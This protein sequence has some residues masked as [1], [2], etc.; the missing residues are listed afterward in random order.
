MEGKL[1]ALNNLLSRRE[2]TKAQTEADAKAK[3]LAD[4]IQLT[5]RSLSASARRR[6][7]NPLIHNDSFTTPGMKRH[8]SQALLYSKMETKYKSLRK[9]FRAIDEDGDQRVS[10]PEL[11]RL[12]VTFNMDPNDRVLYQLFLAADIDGS[13]SIEY[14][15]FQSHFGELLQPSTKGGRAE[16]ALHQRIQSKGKG[17]Q[18]RLHSFKERKGTEQATTMTTTTTSKKMKKKEEK[19]FK[20]SA[21]SNEQFKAK[22]HAKFSSLRGAFRWIDEDSDG[23][24]SWAELKRLL[25]NFNMDDENPALLQLFRLADSNLDGAIDYTEFQKYF[26]ELLQPNSCCSPENNLDGRV[27]KAYVASTKKSPT[28]FVP[29]LDL[30]IAEPSAVAS[31]QEDDDVAGHHTN[32]TSGSGGG[33]PSTMG[34]KLVSSSPVLLLA[35]QSPMDL[36]QKKLFDK[37]RGQ[38][39]KKLNNAFRRADVNRSGTLER[40]EFAAILMEF[41]IGLSLEELNFISLT[42]GTESGS[43]SRMQMGMTL[44][45]ARKMP[46]RPSSALLSHRAPYRNWAGSLRRLHTKSGS[47]NFEFETNGNRPVSKRCGR[48]ISAIAKSHSMRNTVSTMTTSIRARRIRYPEFIKNYVMQQRKNHSQTQ[49]TPLGQG[50]KGLTLGQN[51]ALLNLTAE[52]SHLL[53]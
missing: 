23:Q 36:L 41:G 26:G 43:M 22:L 27:G 25:R 18:H 10:W 46:P 3:A 40:G 8:P 37:V 15:E 39:W 28:L 29:K 24:V 2:Q 13:G 52:Y 44:T 51:S 34:K 53:A 7:K 45:R 32:S 33:T 4:H 48:P 11:Q 19:V 1:G 16:Q 9:A 31:T 30:K 38:D 20:Q 14:S 5:G 21:S 49:G 42:M 6:N 47:R 35:Q 12:L 50:M 17:L